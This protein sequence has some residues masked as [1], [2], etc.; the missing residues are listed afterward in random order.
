MAEETAIRGKDKQ[1]TPKAVRVMDMLA[2]GRSYYKIQ[3]ILGVTRKYIT[4][5]RKIAGFSA[6]HNK[7]IHDGCT[8]DLLRIHEKETL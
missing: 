2:R 4:D 8:P 5:V 1:L 7:M 6:S 3:K